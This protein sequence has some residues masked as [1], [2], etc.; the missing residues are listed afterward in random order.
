MK[1]SIPMVHIMTQ[2]Q[3]D[4]FLKIM[5]LIALFVFITL[6]FVTAGY[7]K[8]SSK[9]WGPIIPNNIGW[10]IMEAPVFIVMCYLWFF[11][12]YK[13]DKIRTTFFLFFQT[14]YFQRSFIFPLLFKS[15]STMPILVMLMGV[16]FNTCNGLM[17]GQWLFYLASPDYYN[18]WEY[19]PKFYIGIIIFIIG[20]S[21]NLHSDHV[22][23]NLRKPGDHN[24]YLP[25]K[26]L[27]QYVTSANY[28]GEIT[29]WTG[30]AIMTWSWA[31]LVFVWWTCANLVPRSFSIYERYRQQFGEK[32]LEKKRI[33]PFIL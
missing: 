13:N 19:N 32:V 8:F 23:R 18:G 14:H 27:Y 5:S 25:N 6:F 29:E 30:F 28:F 11:S 26:G 31:G 22:I 24:H 10:I 3:F 21:I 15:T 33:F 7:G 1:G 2:D 9:R 17:Q 12:E 20:M 4:M 16:V